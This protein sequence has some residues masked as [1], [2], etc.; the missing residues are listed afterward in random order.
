MQKVLILKGLPASGKTTY[1]KSLVAQG[2]WKRINKDDLRAMLDSSI[3][4]KKNES[5]INE[6][7]EALMVG[8]LGCGWNVV[9]DDTNFFPQHE[10]SI[11]ER[12]QVLSRIYEKP[13][14]V[15]VK[16]F[17]VPLE[18]CIARDATRGEKSVGEKVIR[19]MHNRYLAKKTTPA[20]T[21]PKIQHDPELCG[22]FIFDIDGTLAHMNGKRG[23]F[24]WNKVGGDDPDGTLVYL[25]KIISTQNRIIIFSG[26]DECCRTETE[27]WLSDY[28]V[29]FSALFMRPEGDTRKDSIVKEELYNNH[30]KGKYNVMAVFDDRDQVV[31]MWRGLG[32]Q[33][34]QVAP[35]NF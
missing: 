33:C 6:S 32:L 30:I 4:S 7:K 11:R 28:K 34:F 1:A 29:P 31:E 10:A 2:N 27:Q 9:I 18:E 26:R 15:E 25:T 12:V 8:A 23:P 19:G 24:E 17:D 5:F 20:V 22:V 3:H 35:G 14:A 21:I 13:M 16:F